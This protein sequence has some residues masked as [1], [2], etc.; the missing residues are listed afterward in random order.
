MKE[1]STGRCLLTFQ[2]HTSYV[3]S[4]SLSA[5]HRYA[6]SGSWDEILRL[7]EF[8]WELEAHDPVNWDTGARPHLEVLLTQHTPYAGILPAD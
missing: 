5:N 7:W 4:V 2:G 6:L 8:D 3:T 1:V